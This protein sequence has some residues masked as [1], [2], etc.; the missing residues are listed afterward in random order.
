VVETLIKTV[1]LDLHRNEL[2]ALLRQLR[3]ERL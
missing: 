2:T 3:S 1:D